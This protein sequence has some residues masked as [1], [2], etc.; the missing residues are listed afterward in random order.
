MLEQQLRDQ[1]S[2][3]GQ[4]LGRLWLWRRLMWCWIGFA[5]LALVW[6]GLGRPFGF[7]IGGIF[8][9]AWLTATILW[10]RSKSLSLARADIARHVERAFPELDSRLLAALEQCPDVQSGRWNVLQRQ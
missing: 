1:M 7:A 4:R 5:G 3:V 2:L 8:G 6:L 10:G 9:A